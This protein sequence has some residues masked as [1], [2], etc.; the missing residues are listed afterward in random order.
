M[1]FWRIPLDVEEIQITRGVVHILEERCKGCGYCIEFC[2]R[3]VLAFSSRFNERGYNPPVIKNPDDC[4]NC[5]YCEII[6]PEFAI[7][8]IEISEQD[9]K[10]PDPR[11][12]SN[13]R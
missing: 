5:H 13:P 1:E 8:S 7:Y 4:V 9:D 6:C 10:R 2:P 12:H 3:Q 11:L